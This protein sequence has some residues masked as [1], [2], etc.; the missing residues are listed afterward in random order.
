MWYAEKFNSAGEANPP[1]QLVW[2]EWFWDCLE[3]GGAYSAFH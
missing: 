1:F 2:D 3:Y